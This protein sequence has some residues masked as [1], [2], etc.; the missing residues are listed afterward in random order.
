MTDTH[1][2]PGHRTTTCPPGDTGTLHLVY[3]TT[4]VTTVTDTPGLLSPLKQ[5]SAECPG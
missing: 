3:I 2:D 1:N 5:G 4:L